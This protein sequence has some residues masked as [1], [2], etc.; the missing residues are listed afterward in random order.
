MIDTLRRQRGEVIETFILLQSVASVFEDAGPQLCE[1][2]THSLPTFGRCLP[3]V[4]FQGI[5][6]TLGFCSS[7]GVGD[8]QKNLIKFK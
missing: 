8:Y 2:L 5:R 4:H 1:Y 7:Q 6:E 3:I